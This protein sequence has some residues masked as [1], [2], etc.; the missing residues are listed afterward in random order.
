[1]ITGRTILCFA[2]G[3]DAPPTSK[4]HI[5]H[6]LARRNTVLWVNYH[7]SRRPRVRPCDMLR[8]AGRLCRVF[9]G[10]VRA[11][12]NLYVL[13]PLVLPLPG[14]WW[15]RRLNCELLSSQ[16]RSAMAS[17]GDGPAQIWSFCPDVSYLLGR[18]NAERTL[19]YCVDDFA[20]FSGY[21]RR[22]VLADEQELCRR[23]DLVVASSRALYEAK[24]PLNDR[25]IFVPH[26][27]DFSHFAG[28]TSGRCEVPR[29]MS[30]IG[31]PRIGFFGLIRDWV[32]LELVAAV[33]RRRPLWH[34]VF[35]GDSSVDLSA[36]GGLA[37]VHFLG[38]KPYRRLPCYCRQFDA[39]MIPFKVNDLTRSANP[40]KLREYLA[41]GLGVV[42]TPLPEVEAYRGLVEIADGPEGFAA[43]IE[44][45]LHAGD[46]ARRQRVEAMRREDWPVKLEQICE[47]LMNGRRQ[48]SAAAAER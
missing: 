48:A 27:V 25:T 43:A 8:M 2:S 28:A 1:M 14:L 22:Q 42:S 11:R 10:L 16:I 38:P 23:A 18:F 9:R 34:F 40:I 7:A 32:D 5:M 13:T 35:L 19:Y 17:V 30:A 3:Y 47:C 41:A 36:A 15:A 20:A 46:K 33:A 44:R 39:A 21:D 29:D 12:R 45:L 31:R 37:N 24:L 6:L 26:G 4:H